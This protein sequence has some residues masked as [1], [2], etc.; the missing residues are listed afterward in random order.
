[1]MAEMTGAQAVSELAETARELLRMYHEVEGDAIS[2]YGEDD[3][4][5]ASALD[6]ECDRLLRRIGHLERIAIS[7]R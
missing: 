2:Q 5:E 7:G 6:A 1:M 4:A 3:G